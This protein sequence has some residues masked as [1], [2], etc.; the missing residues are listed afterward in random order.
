MVQMVSDGLS[1]PNIQFPPGLP[2]SIR[3]SLSKKSKTW[4]K[5]WGW[6]LQTPLAVF[7]NPNLKTSLG[8][9]TPQNGFIRLNPTLLAENQTLTPEVFCH[10]LAHIAVFY[11]YGPTEKPH[12]QRW[13]ELMRLAGFTPRVSIANTHHFFKTNADKSSG[14]YYRHTCPVCQAS[15]ISSRPQPGWRCASCT[16][17]GLDGK[18]IIESYPRKESKS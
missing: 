17:A 1:M 13:Q 12:G 9:C 16:E 4:I 10:E 7:I 11:L 8:S 14:I 5:Q 6:D 15:R 3:R 18:M 2:T